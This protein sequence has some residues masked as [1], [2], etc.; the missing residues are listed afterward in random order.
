[1]KEHWKIIICWNLSFSQKKVNLPEFNSLPWIHTV[2]VSSEIHVESES[3]VGI[4]QNRVADGKIS[5]RK[6]TEKTNN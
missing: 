4:E 1:M 2:K 3:H 6:Q 5:R